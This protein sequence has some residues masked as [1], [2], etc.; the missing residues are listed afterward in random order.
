VGRP[1]HLNDNTIVLEV[2]VCVHRI[3]DVLVLNH[4]KKSSW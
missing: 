1:E 3:V 4:A 2:N